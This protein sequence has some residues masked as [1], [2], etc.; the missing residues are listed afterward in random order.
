MADFPHIWCHQFSCYNHSLGINFTTHVFQM[1][2]LYPNSSD[3]HLCQ[4]GIFAFVSFLLIPWWIWISTWMWTQLY[5]MYGSVHSTVT[6]ILNILHRPH[7]APVNII[8]QPQTN[9]IRHA[10]HLSYTMPTTPSPYGW[11]SKSLSSMDTRLQFSRSSRK[12]GGRSGSW[13]LGKR[14]KVCR[15]ICW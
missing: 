2:A 15:G 13:T 5:S 14:T 7:P 10:R 11:W 12:R 1:K 6:I 9:C 4:Y 8:W 3:H